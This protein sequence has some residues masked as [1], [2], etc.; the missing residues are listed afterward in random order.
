MTK[1]ENSVVCA[2]HFCASMNV[3]CFKVSFLKYTWLQL[4]MYPFS[5]KYYIAAPYCTMHNI[6]VIEW[7]ICFVQIWWLIGEDGVTPWWRWGDSLVKMMLLIGEDG[8]T[9]CWRWGD[10]LLKMGWLKG[11]Y[12][13][14]WLIGE[15]GVA[16]RWTSGDS[17]SHWRRCGGSQLL[18]RLFKNLKQAC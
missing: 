13:M 2:P 11:E 8:V 14:W 7:D 4:H 6:I 3:F 12:C 1:N 10:W 15:E 17:L 16:S 9:D 5:K 18:K